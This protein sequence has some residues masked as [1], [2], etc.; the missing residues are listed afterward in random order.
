MNAASAIVEGTLDD[1]LAKFLKKNIVKKE[2]KDEVRVVVCRPL[3]HIAT[4]ILVHVL[5]Q[6]IV[7]PAPVYACMP[8]VA[9][10][11]AY[12]HSHLCVRVAGVLLHLHD[13]LL[14]SHS[15]LCVRVAGVLLHLY[16]TCSW[17]SW[18]FWTTS[19]VG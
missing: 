1:S 11:P 12:S 18:A 3:A 13:I 19:W 2:L 7:S 14:S 10:V 17:Y 8:E 9:I 15:H 4:L 5:L 6:R 16:D